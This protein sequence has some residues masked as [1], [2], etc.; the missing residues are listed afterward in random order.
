MRKITA[1]LLV[2][3]A[4]AIV[5]PA[6]AFA[7]GQ[8]SA[9]FAAAWENLPL[10]VRSDATTCGVEADEAFDSDS[11]TGTL[12]ATMKT[13]TGKEILAGISAESKIALNTGV[14]AKNGGSA[15]AT[16]SGLVKVRVKAVNVA[17]GQIYLPVPSP[18]ITLHARVQTLSATLGGVI[19]SCTD[20]N[21]DGTIDVGTECVVSDEE[22]ALFT[23]HTS[24]NHFNVVFADLPSG[25][26]QVR[27]K[28][29][30]RSSAAAS[31]SGDDACA[32]AGSYVILKDRIVTLEGVRAVKGAIEVL[33]VD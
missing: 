18:D 12:L 13:P 1:A 2:A 31:D 32:Y 27:A 3:T 21:G 17:T 16:A 8:P 19:E 29:T 28:F 9:K 30:I 20:A 15:E 4:L 22:I 10:A 5:A 25:V 7:Q 33:E 6:P 26:Y 24:A 23:S 14:R 11:A